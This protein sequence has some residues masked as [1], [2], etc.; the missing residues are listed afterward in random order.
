MVR[1]KL[2]LTGRK[3]GKITVLHEVARKKRHRVW[4]CRCD[5]GKEKSVLQDNLINKHAQSCGCL[6]NK[7]S[8]IRMT[9]RHREGLSRKPNAARNDLLR[10]Y[11]AGARKRGIAFSLSNAEFGTLIEGSCYYC[12]ELPTTRVQEKNTIL[13][14]GIDRK[15]S[16]LGYIMDNCVSC[17]KICNLAKLTMAPEE[18]ITHCRKVA[19]FST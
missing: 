2:D 12:G 6:R 16:A 8:S 15:D 1:Q 3:F 5:C 19:Q 7:M 18:F 9:A 13:A 10:T 14:N 4:L 11:M 17:C